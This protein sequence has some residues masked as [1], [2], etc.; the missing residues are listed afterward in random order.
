MFALQYINRPGNGYG[1]Y[2]VHDDKGIV[3]VKAT[4]ATDIRPLYLWLGN[5]DDIKGR[6]MMRNAFS[7]PSV[8]L[9]PAQ[10]NAMVCGM[11][12]HTERSFVKEG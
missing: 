1:G 11:P 7:M 2:V 4:S 12:L 8:V 3:F 6:D 5:G 10:Y 9:N